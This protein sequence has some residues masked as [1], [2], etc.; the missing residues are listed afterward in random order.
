MPV[1]LGRSSVLLGLTVLVA[2]STAAVGVRAL[3]ERPSTARQGTSMQR[4]VPAPGSG[5]SLAPA[6]TLED[7]AALTPAREPPA[8]TAAPPRTSARPTAV[9]TVAP[10]RSTAPRERVDQPGWKLIFDEDFATP[11]VPGSFLSTYPNFGAYPWGWLDSSKRGHYDPNIL[12]V[13]GGKLAM[14]LHT[15]SD[16]THHVAAP[17]PKLPGG[18]SNQLYGRYSVRFRADPVDGYKTAWLLW[19]QS[20]VWSDGE[21]DFPEGDLTGTIKA[22]MH[23]VG[24]PTQQDY[25]LTGSGYADWHTATIEWSPNRVAFYFDGRLIGT[26]TQHV[27]T[28]PMHFVLQTETELGSDPVPSIT[29]G[30]VQVDWV[31]IWR[32]AP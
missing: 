20:E 5:G 8:A 11:A 19:P 18:G 3:A 28:K 26:S 16:G 29:A 25:F 30:N 1:T 17:Y 15:S 12:S 7:M 32:Y 22:F 23:H 4:T 9:P 24:A 6:P 13:S 21:I 27:P 2:A 31:S 10:R 14:H